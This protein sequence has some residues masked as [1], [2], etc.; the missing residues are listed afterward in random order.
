MLVMQIAWN[1]LASTTLASPGPQAPPSSKLKCVKK[2]SGGSLGTSLVQHI[3][4]HVS[5]LQA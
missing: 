4:V 1:K 5:S 2:R 3:N